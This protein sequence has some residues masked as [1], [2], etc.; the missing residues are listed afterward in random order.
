MQGF[1]ANVLGDFRS[2]DVRGKFYNL[3]R[4]QVIMGMGVMDRGSADAVTAVSQLMM[5]LGAMPRSMAEA[6]VI[7]FMMDPG[8]NVSATALFL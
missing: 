4:G 6:T 1:W 5:V 7:T 3:S 8:S 2:A